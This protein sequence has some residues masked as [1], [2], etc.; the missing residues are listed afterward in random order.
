MMLVVSC[1]LAGISFFAKILIGHGHSWVNWL[2]FAG[3]A[4]I[5]FF[6]YFIGNITL[7][8]YVLLLGITTG[9]LMIVLGIGYWRLL[10]K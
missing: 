3:I 7:T 4:S 9:S 6:A 1:C 5:V 10:H 8:Q 2:L